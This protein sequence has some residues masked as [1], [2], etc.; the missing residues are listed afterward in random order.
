MMRHGRSLQPQILGPNNRISVIPPAHGVVAHQD[1]LVVELLNG[2]SRILRRCRRRLLRGWL[3][4]VCWGFMWW[5]LV[6]WCWCVM[7]RWHWRV[8]SWFRSVTS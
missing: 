5:Q 3:R 6:I 7:S 1:P 4:L 8:G 2:R